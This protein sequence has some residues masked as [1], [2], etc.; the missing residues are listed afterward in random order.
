VTW[1]RPDATRR[2]PTGSAG[3]YQLAVVPDPCWPPQK[4]GAA[5]DASQRPRM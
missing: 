2:Q 4:L 5:S 1:I 3:A